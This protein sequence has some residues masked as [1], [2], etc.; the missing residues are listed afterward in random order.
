[1]ESSSRKTWALRQLQQ[2]QLSEEVRK[3]TPSG[4]QED[5]HLPAAGAAAGA[6]A[7]TEEAGFGATGAGVDALGA[8]AATL[9]IS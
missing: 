5:N 9:L 2:G 8:A 3:R 1:M 6:A 7:G 4:E